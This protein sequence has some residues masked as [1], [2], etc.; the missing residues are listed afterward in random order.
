[1]TTHALALCIGAGPEQIG[2]I[3]KAQ[4]L[5]YRVLA[6]DGDPNAPGLALACESRVANICD[7]DAVVTIARSAGVAL[8]LPV[9]IG[10]LLAT[11]GR[12]HDELGLHGVSYETAMICTDKAAFHRCL[13]AA[14]ID[15][16]W[17]CS[18]ETVAELKD[19]NGAEW[20]FPVVIKPTYGS[21][22]RG[23]L[24]LNSEEAWHQ[25][26]QNTNNLTSHYGVGA[27][28]EAFIDGIVLG[29]DGAVAAGE[30]VITTVREKEMTPLPWRVELAYKT[31]SC[32]PNEATPRIYKEISSALKA[33][34]V[35]G[36]TFHADA[37]WTDNGR[38]VIIEMSARPAGLMIT[39]GLV[40]L[41]TGVDFLAEAIKLHATGYGSFEAKYAVPSLL[42]YWHHNGGIVKQLPSS[43]EI[44]QDPHVADVEI[45]LRI[46]QTLHIPAS[47]GELIVNGYM[48]LRANTWTEIED[49]RR[50]AISLI[51][52]ESKQYQ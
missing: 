51:N 23:V 7:V 14:K 26:S 41:S 27:V 50:H 1:M 47:V 19:E 49:S 28:I 18:Y 30:V 3:L 8:T 20:P 4:S 44:L 9:P 22:S 6:L 5:G 21:G 11:Q 32:L 39:R 38:L 46:G 35:D 40:P 25:L 29:I 34:G 16:P 36:S 10:R 15:L 33:L 24:V 37:V 52:I 31:P 48:L 17:Q 42:H 2:S 45:N 12:V 43:K 13:A